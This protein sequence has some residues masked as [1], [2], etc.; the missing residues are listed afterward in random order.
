[1]TSFVP[2]TSAKVIISIH[3]PTQGVTDFD[4]SFL[5]FHVFQSTLPRREWQGLYWNYFY[6][7]WFQST[8]PRREWPIINDP[9]NL[10]LYFNP[11]SHAGSDANDE[12]CV[13]AIWGFQSTLPRREWRDL[14]G[15]FNAIWNDF[16]PH[17]HAG[18]DFVMFK[19]DAHSFDFNP[20]SHAGSDEMTAYNGSQFIIFQSTLPRREW[21]SGE[22]L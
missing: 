10:R 22:L 15:N 19:K 16:N 9:S 18:S 14:S 17:S 8:L 1:M 7:V 11:H 13:Y 2:L 4:P 5:M 12:K 21:P 20:H 6:H 3:T